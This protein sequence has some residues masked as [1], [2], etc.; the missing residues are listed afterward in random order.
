MLGRLDSYASPAASP[1]YPH[2]DAI[3]KLED[4]TQAPRQVQR[5]V[6]IPQAKAD[7]DAVDGMDAHVQA[8]AEHQFLALLAL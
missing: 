4:H 8:G 2:P 7:A 5:P 6:R 3:A 1:G